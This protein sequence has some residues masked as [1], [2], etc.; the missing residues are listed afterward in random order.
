[1][2]PDEYRLTASGKP[3][4]TLPI[5]NPVAE[6]SFLIFAGR[7][8]RVMA[9][10]QEKHVIDLVPAAGGR[11]S[12]FNSG[13][14]GDV[15]DRVRGE[16]HD[17]YVRGDVP[18]YLDVEAAD[19]LHEGRENFVRYGLDRTNFIACGDGTLYFPW[20]GTLAMNTLVQQLAMRNVSASMEGPAIVAHGVKP[21]ELR[22]VAGACEAE[23]S[24]DVV[25]LAAH[26]KNKIEEKW[27][28]ALDEQMLCASYA[29][30]K[31]AKT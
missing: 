13:A 20:Y 27:D 18:S 1:V 25:T 21:A 24:V 10:D 5:V 16:M 2:T 8:W 15:H 7:R 29:S 31:L 11:V 9:V 22:D 6:G 19:L 3:L 12:V 17:I 30:R 23:R 14:R 26:V 4:G 28:W